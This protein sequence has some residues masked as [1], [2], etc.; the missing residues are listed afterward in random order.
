M[1]D[2]TKTF[3]K[4]T[5]T[6]RKQSEKGASNLRL[7]GGSR[8]LVL[9]SLTSRSPLRRAPARGTLGFLLGEGIPAGRGPKRGDFACFAENFGTFLTFAP[10]C[11]E[12]GWLA[13]WRDDAGLLAAEQPCLED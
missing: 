3:R 10:D 7:S 1:L 12:T 5:K 11:D 9:A 4:N 6:F 2:T 13:G 8:G